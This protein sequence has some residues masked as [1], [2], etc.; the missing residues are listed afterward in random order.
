MNILSCSQYR[1]RLGRDVDSTA[2][3]WTN[4]QFSKKS[5]VVTLDHDC[6]NAL[7]AYL[8]DVALPELQRQS[9]ESQSH[10][11]WVQRELGQS[12]KSFYLQKRA[13]EKS[14][15]DK[16]IESPDVFNKLAETL[17]RKGFDIS[18]S[19]IEI[20]LDAATVLDEEESHLSYS[21]DK[22]R[23]RWHQDAEDT[24]RLLCTLYGVKTPYVTPGV[25]VWI[26][27]LPEEEDN[28]YRFRETY[29]SL[30][31]ADEVFL[32]G[33]GVVCS[34][35]D[36]ADASDSDEDKECQSPAEIEC[37]MNSVVRD[38]VR[39]QLLHGFV[40]AGEI[41]RTPPVELGGKLYKRI[42]MIMDQVVVVCGG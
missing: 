24:S 27:R 29:E 10:T 22:N 39:E 25:S 30:V 40:T 28:T 19:N 38:G 17:F 32:A 41:D 13:G 26:P 35:Y 37:I 16:I 8:E 31:V 18:C 14:E 15:V 23:R 21:A 1:E 3:S 7:W 20:R 9:D 11:D 5:G 33:G 2:D 4:P 6:L 42:F 34:T 12:Q 36:A